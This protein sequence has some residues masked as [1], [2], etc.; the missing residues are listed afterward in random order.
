[1][2]GEKWARAGLTL[3]LIVFMAALVQML[4]IVWTAAIGALLFGSAEILVH[5]GGLDVRTFGTSN[6]VALGFDVAVFVV[7]GTRAIRRRMRGPSESTERFAQRHPMSAVALAFAAGIAIVAVL[8]WMPSPYFPAPLATMVVL[9][10][11]YYYALFAVFGSARLAGRAWRRLRTWGL[12]SAYRT[13]LLTSAL[14]LVG[15][16]G[17]YLLTARWFDE[18]EDEVSAAF[19]EIPED[20]DLSTAEL[21]GLCIVA[22]EIDATAAAAPRASACVLAPKVDRDAC[23]ERLMRDDVP[24]V[25]SNLRSRKYSWA[26]V[27]DAVAKA[28]LEACTRADVKNPA[29]YFRTVARNTACRLAINAPRECPELPDEA[30]E[31]TWDAGL[32]ASDLWACAKRELDDD[33]LTVI[34]RRVKFGQSNKEIGEQLGMKATTV[35]EQFSYGIKRLRIRCRNQQD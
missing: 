30:T 6:L 1:M 9:A 7:I 31:P 29:A 2:Q 12:S 21:D 10:A 24:S 33:V 17:V 35:K 4:A 25:R 3:A 32:A 16:G 14:V 5:T 27:D 18:P 11:A 34:I 8:G 28:L 26:E 22:G 20:A 19:A 23:F 15:I 13:G